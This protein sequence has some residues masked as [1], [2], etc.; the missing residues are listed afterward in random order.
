MTTAKDF[1]AGVNRLEA[2]RA[3]AAKIPPLTFRTFR[4]RVDFTFAAT[5][6]QADACLRRVAKVYGGATLTEHVGAWYDP[7]GAFWRETSFTLTVYTS[8]GDRAQTTSRRV[9]DTCREL[10]VEASQ[11]ALV[12]S[13]T[14][15]SG[16]RAAEVSR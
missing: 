8:L 12:V 6:E 2:E 1:I 3:E 10:L 13:V 15:S 9:L 16:M 7:E 14:N 4:T 11:R 5:H